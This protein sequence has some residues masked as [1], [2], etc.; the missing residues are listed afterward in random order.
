MS[1]TLD[2]VEQLIGCPSVTPKD[3]QCMSWIEQ[4]LKRMGFVCERMDKGPADAMVSNLWAI[5]RSPSPQAK[6]LVFAGHTDVVPTGP[7]DK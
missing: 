7:L 3:A 5:K 6:T 4:R 2:L 1:P